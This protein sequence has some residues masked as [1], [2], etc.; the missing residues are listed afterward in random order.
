MKVP[1]EVHLLAWSD[2]LIAE[3]YEIKVLPVLLHVLSHLPIAEHQL[4]PKPL[5]HRLMK[6]DRVHFFELLSHHGF[7]ELKLPIWTLK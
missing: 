5:G 7:S 6:A 2:H 1:N 4:C 3:S